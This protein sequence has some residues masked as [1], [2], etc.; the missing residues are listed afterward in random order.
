MSKLEKLKQQ[1]GS[2]LQL[3][4]TLEEKQLDDRQIGGTILANA[5]KNIIQKELLPVREA[6]G[7]ANVRS[8]EAD[9]GRRNN[10]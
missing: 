1:F 6:M 9:R 10:K 5:I 2:F 7:R 4:N 8:V 3:K